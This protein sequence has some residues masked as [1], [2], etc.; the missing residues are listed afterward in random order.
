MTYQ[1]SGLSAIS[2]ANGFTLWHYRTND[3]A[4]DVLSNCYF[5]AA[6][7]MLR[8]GDFMFI[9]AGIDNLPHHGMVVITSNAGGKVVVCAHFP[10]TQETDR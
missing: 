2:Y 5:N 7:K 10:F 6:T 4:D 3:R 1:S 9:T 8:Q